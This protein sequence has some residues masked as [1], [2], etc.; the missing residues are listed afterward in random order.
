MSNASE[1]VAEI[2]G[3]LD[4]SMLKHSNITSTDIIEFIEC[5]WSIMDEEKYKIH[6][7]NIII[8]RMVNEYI[9]LKDI[10]NV[11][12]WLTIGD[13]HV[14][15]KINEDYIVNYYR[16]ECLYACGAEDDAL[17]YFST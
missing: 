6:N 9:K 15:R 7:A 2:Y 1:K 12:R 3:F 17:N 8:A 5:Q 14:N 13:N 16:G 11:K 4:R 10:E